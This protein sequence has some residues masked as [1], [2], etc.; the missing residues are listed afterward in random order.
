MR[1]RRLQRVKTL[2][3]RQERMPPEGDN[4]RF[5]IIA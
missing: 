2:I 5:L 4:D 1:D 3:Q